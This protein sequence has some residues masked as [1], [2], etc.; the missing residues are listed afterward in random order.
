[1]RRVYLLTGLE[2]RKKHVK[3]TFET[4]QFHYI[5]LARKQGDQKQK[6]FVRF[7]QQANHIGLLPTIVAW[8]F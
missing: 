7:N 4:Y 2:K 3:L 6:G 5:K 8:A 1:M